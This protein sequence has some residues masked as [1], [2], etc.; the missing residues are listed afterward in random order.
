MI[1]VASILQKIKKYKL[2]EIEKL[3][4]VRTIRKWEEEALKAPPIR[5]FLN[6]LVEKKTTLFQYNS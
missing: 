2:K 1:M 5:G 6:C 4:E 3:R